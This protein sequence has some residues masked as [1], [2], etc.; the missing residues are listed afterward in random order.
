MFAKIYLEHT[1]YRLSSIHDIPLAESLYVLTAA[2][3]GFQRLHEQVGCF[4]PTEDMIGIDC[5]GRIKVWLNPNFSRHHIFG[6]QILEDT[7][8]RSQAKMV[9][10]VVTIIDQNTVD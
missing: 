10:E 5:E 8:R 2:L 6:P 9:M 7:P 1:P 3:A 4:H